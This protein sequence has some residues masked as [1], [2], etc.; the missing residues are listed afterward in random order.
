MKDEESQSQIP[1]SHPD[2]QYDD[3]ISGIPYSSEEI[4]LLRRCVQL[5]QHKF[6]SV[7]H[8]H[9]YLS[10]A[11]AA[12]KTPSHVIQGQIRPMNILKGHE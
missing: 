5:M 8:H 7:F 12:M 11:Q 4:A 2:D 1:E 3:S 10:P 9:N 6:T